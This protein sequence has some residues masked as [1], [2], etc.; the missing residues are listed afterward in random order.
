MYPKMTA[1]LTMTDLAGPQA[2][3][4]LADGRE[5]ILKFVRSKVRDLDTAEDIVQDVLF[6]LVRAVDASETIEDMGAWLYHAARNRV[7]DWYRKKKHDPMTD[8][9]AQTAVAEKTGGDTTLMREEIWGTLMN[10]L[11][12]LPEKQRDVFVMHELEGFSFNEIQE[13]TGEN[14]NTLLAR[15]RYAVLELRKQ[16]KHLR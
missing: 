10:A 3:E 1:T 14:L 7:I 15:K 6:Q 13:I 12:E 16:L 8:A 2:G 11:S 4:I 5:S 9:I